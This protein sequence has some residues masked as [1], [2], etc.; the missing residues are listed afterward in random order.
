MHA[1]ADSVFSI[2]EAMFVIITCAYTVLCTLPTCINSLGWSRIP[3]QMWTSHLMTRHLA[4]PPWSSKAAAVAVH[5][6]HQP[7]PCQRHGFDIFDLK[8]L[9]IHSKGII[10]LN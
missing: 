1:S 8:E 4:R 2:F 9:A 7:C 5:W 6:L 10:I 3:L